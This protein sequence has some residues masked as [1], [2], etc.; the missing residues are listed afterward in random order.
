M[1]RQ[2]GNSPTEIALLLEAFDT[3][4]EFLRSRRENVSRKRRHDLECS[5]AEVEAALT[6]LVAGFEGASRDRLKFIQAT[7]RQAYGRASRLEAWHKDGTYNRPA[8][9]LVN[10]I[11]AARMYYWLRTFD[12]QKTWDGLSV[13]ELREAA[14]DP[15]IT[16]SGA[17]AVAGLIRQLAD[18]AIV[19]TRQLDAATDDCIEHIVLF[20]LDI[21]ELLGEQATA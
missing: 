2:T 3:L 18:G 9:M 21:L 19:T 13:D 17:S 14:R 5:L 1:A 20:R 16:R 6:E 12:S 8:D 15:N 4:V 7:L 10:M 11:A